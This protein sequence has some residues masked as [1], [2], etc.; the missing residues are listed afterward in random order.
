MRIYN[1]GNHSRVRGRFEPRHEA[2]AGACKVTKASPAEVEAMLAERWPGKIE[3]IRHAL[4]IRLR[5]K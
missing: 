1:N 2:L 4:P 5:G 3:P